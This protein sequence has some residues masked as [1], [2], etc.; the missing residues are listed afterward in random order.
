MIPMD[1]R[2][3]RFWNRM[4]CNLTRYAWQSLVCLLVLF[5]ALG[6]ARNGVIGVENWQ[7]TNPP[8]LSLKE[9]AQAYQE[10]LEDWHQMDDGLIRYRRWA[11]G[12]AELPGYG[13]LADGCFFLGIY[14]ASQALRLAATGDP[15]AREQ[16]LVSLHAMKLYAEVSGEPGLLARYFSPVKPDDDRWRKS[17][18][19]PEY[20]WRSDVSRDQYAGYIH[21]LGVTLAVVSAPEIRSQIAPLASAIADHLIEN[22][23]QIIDWDKKRTTYGDLR[24]RISGVIPNGVNA[25][26]C[27]AIFKVA[28]ES[29]GEQKYIDFYGKLVPESRS[30][31]TSTASLS[32]MG[33]R[34]SHAGPTSPPSARM[35]VSTPTWRMS[36][37]TRSCSWKTMKRLFEKSGRGLCGCGPA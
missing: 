33:T 22:D 12:H 3:G 16:V 1:E 10:R 32:R 26:I 28:A 11:E 13:N 25:L 23:L 4:E 18:T 14:L 31:S 9:R 24:G 20:F 35:I 27:L 17:Q 36:R 19:H 21:G 6:C 37:S 15:E 5:T 34:A 7:D 29:T 8:K 2:V 30:T